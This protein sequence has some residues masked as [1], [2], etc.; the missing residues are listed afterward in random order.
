MHLIFISLF[1]CYTFFDKFAKA[2]DHGY[3]YVSN[4]VVD[5][6][7]PKPDVILKKIADL[8][9]NYYMD[10]FVRTPEV[11]KHPGFSILARSDILIQ[12]AMNRQGLTLESLAAIAGPQ[13]SS[14]QSFVG[15]LASTLSSVGGAQSFVSMGLG[16][17]GSLASAMQAGQISTLDQKVSDKAEATDLA[18]ASTRIGTLETKLAA[19][20]ATISTLS[21]SSTS[22]A[23]SISSICTA[24]KAYQA[25]GSGLTIDATYGGTATTDEMGMLTKIKAVA[26]PTCS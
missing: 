13:I 3:Q 17:V 26:A 4:D 24:V 8:R 20:E 18:L 23:S 22:S 1:F 9:D 11:V 21:G 7:S 12:E 25:A 6:E 2:S 5:Y 15:S 16:A 14:R 19:A 10:E